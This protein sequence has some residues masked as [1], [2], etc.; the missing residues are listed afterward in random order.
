ME[1]SL[2]T[3]ESIKPKKSLFRKFLKFL[4]WLIFIFILLLS[5]AVVLVFVYEDDVKAVIIKELNKNLNAE[6][7]INPDDID[8]TIV[9]TFPDCALEFKNITCM[10]AVKRK[11]KDTLLFA[12]TIQLKFD[13]K[14]LWNGKYDI[15]KI[16]VHDAFCRMKIDKKG[17]PN[18][19]VWKSSG[20]ETNKNDSLT[21]NLEKIEIKNTNWS[22]KK[23]KEELEINLFVKQMDFMGA[24]NETNYD[25]KGNGNL[26]INSF[27]SNGQTFIKNKNLNINAAL[28]IN[29]NKYAISNCNLM[30]NDMEI[31]ATGNMLYNDSLSGLALNFKGKNLDIQS[32]LSLLPEKYKSK[33]NNY[34]SEG[35]IYAEGN[36]NYNK[37]W[38]TEVDFGIVNTQV[39]YVP[40]NT[41]LNNLNCKGK[42]ISNQKLTF[43]QLKEINAGLMNDHFSGNFSLTNFTDPVLNVEASGNLN[44]GNIIKFW[45]ID[46]LAVLSGSVNFNSKISGK[47]NELKKNVLSE[48]ALITLNAA[49]KDLIIGFKGQIDSTKVATCDLSAVDRIIE[50]KNLQINKGQSDALINGKLEGVWNYI[51]DKTKV[52]KINGSLKSNLLHAEDF[53]LVDNGNASAKKELDIADNLHF[54]L[55]ATIKKFTLGKFIAQNISGGLELKNKKIL[56]ESIEMETMDGKASLDALFDFTGSNLNVSSV[57]HLSNI[58]VN[59]LFTQFNNFGQ[60]TLQDKN[61]AGV[62]TAS[63]DFSGS[64]TKF[65]EPD[66]NS[67][68]SVA[69]III[70]NGALNEFKPLESL[71]KF[72]DIN[73]LKNIKFSTMQSQIEIRK[74]LIIIP[75]TAIKNS[76]LNIDFWGT[77]SFNNDIDYH[78]QLLISELM[79]KKRKNKSDEEFGPIEN[80]PENR[81]SA[82]VLMTGT[83]DKPIIKYDKQGLKQ[84]IKEDIK[85]EKQNLK[86]LLKEEF[87]LF[88]KDS[89]K[90][91]EKNKADQNFK[92]ETENKKDKKKEEEDEDD[93]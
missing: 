3:N 29:E 79:A 33:I 41:A 50:V 35:T 38:S 62:L 89:I 12:K 46:T 86:Q 53:I 16:A 66:L 31:D 43:F 51:T 78:I 13:V 27:L 9:K 2:H 67:I 30:L 93:F 17:N 71:S 18:Y 84:K 1:N 37:N 40:E 47:I 82:F 77:H 45:P 8:L 26:Q 61:I 74:G 48:S 10:E 80:D 32:M 44:L 42:L 72:V 4:F 54:T 39:V 76:A 6:V 88:K 23:G 69:N 11:N 64:W 34:K 87:G 7:R 68:K 59:K 25:L 65:L 63:I 36:V 73:D 5:T 92:L 52:L 57:S 91:N 70:N 90:V 21:F 20:K 60:A 55:D 15:K 19:V 81:R 58:N 14:D 83:V 56:A 24:F 85:Q 28:I 75:K 49:F 22:F